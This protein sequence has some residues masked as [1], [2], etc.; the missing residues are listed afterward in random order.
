[1]S[2]TRTS[3]NF[4]QSSTEEQWGGARCA[5]D[6]LGYCEHELDDDFRSY[7]VALAH[8]GDLQPQQE[9]VIQDFRRDFVY[10]LG[11]PLLR[12]NLRAC[13]VCFSR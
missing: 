7:G 12:S 10:G 2:S 8:S 13:T 5:L 9:E 3:L 4:P 11:Q 6:V 1:M